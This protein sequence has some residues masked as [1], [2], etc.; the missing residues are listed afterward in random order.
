MKHL[1]EDPILTIFSEQA[2]K[3]LSPH[4]KETILFGSRARGDHS[5][6]SD[7]D[8]LMI[9]DEVSNDLKDRLDEIAGDMLYEYN[10]VFSAF[11]ISEKRYQTSPFNPL[12]MNV[13]REGI[14]L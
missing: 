2:H 1:E 6:E 10:A 8:C 12:L 14:S 11:P 4:L 3:Q 13:Q 9:L 5:S 7:Y